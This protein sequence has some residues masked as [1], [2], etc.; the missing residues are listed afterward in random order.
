MLYW[1]TFYLPLNLMDEVW[2]LVRIMAVGVMDHIF[3]FRYFL[4]TVCFFIMILIYCPYLS[5]WILIL[6]VLSEMVLKR[7]YFP[8]SSI[9]KLSNTARVLNVWVVDVSFLYCLK[10][11]WIISNF[12]RTGMSGNFLYKDFSTIK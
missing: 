6:F 4:C 8:P 12:K 9:M 2:W 5:F 7:I 10:I 1:G 11:K 3:V